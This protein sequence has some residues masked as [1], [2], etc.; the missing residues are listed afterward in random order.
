MYKNWLLPFLALSLLV[1]HACKK[2]ESNS[3]S[4]TGSKLSAAGAANKSASSLF[5]GKIVVQ[6]KQVHPKPLP[7]NHALAASFT[8]IND[9]SEGYLTGTNLISLSHLTTYQL[10]NSVSDNR[11]TVLSSSNMSKLTAMAAES[12]S[13]NAVWGYPPAVEGN[14]PDVLFSNAQNAITLTLSQPVR[15]FGFELQGATYGN[16]AI[17]ASFYN[18]GTFMGSI[19]RTTT[20]QVSGTEGAKLFAASTDAQFDK[21]IIEIDPQILAAGFALAQLRYAQSLNVAVDIKPGTCPNAFNTKSNGVL[22]VAVLGTATF[23]VNDID[24]S[25]IRINGVSPERTSLEDVSAPL[26][27]RGDCDCAPRAPD[28]KTDLTVKMSSAL[29]RALPVVVNAADG[30]RVS[31]TLS[32]LLKNGQPFEGRDCIVVKKK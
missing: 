5:A 14:N 11:L 20:A 3:E 17:T 16:V 19:T 24:R 13:W 26:A 32:G 21:V 31:L 25:T 15:L 2:A 28:G 1:M 6:K 9:V 7:G 18:G 8:P 29:V 10:V 12:A 4:S 23:N 30:D 22:P 27:K